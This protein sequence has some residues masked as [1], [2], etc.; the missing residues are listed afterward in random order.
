MEK[1]IKI[2]GEAKYIDTIINSQKTR[3]KAGSV[4]LTEIKPKKKSE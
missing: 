3:I 2:T 1:T 4:K